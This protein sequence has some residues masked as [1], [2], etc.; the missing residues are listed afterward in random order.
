MK[1]TIRLQKLL[2]PSSEM[3]HRQDINEL[4]GLV[5]TADRFIRQLPSTPA[6]FD[7]LSHLNVAC[8]GIVEEPGVR[9]AVALFEHLYQKLL[10]RRQR[11]ALGCRESL[12]RALIDP[13]FEATL[14]A[15]DA[16]GLRG[17]YRAMML[18]P[19]VHLL[20][21]LEQVATYAAQRKVMAR[22]KLLSAAA[23][24]E[25]DGIDAELTFWV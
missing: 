19:L 15:T 6:G 10:A 25:L 24:V 16:M 7:I 20:M 4:K 21:C 9:H 23:G 12:I 1:E 11:R 14:D 13:V 2:G 3:H 22:K 17:E 5:E 18:G 8:K